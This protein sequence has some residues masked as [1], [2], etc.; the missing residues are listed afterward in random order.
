MGIEKAQLFF[1]EFIGESAQDLVLLAQSG[2]ARKNFVGQT[3]DKKYIITS[4][5][6]IAENESF[7]YFSNLFSDLHLNT[8]EILKI[9]DD[10]KMY[11]QEFLGAQTLSKI[12]ADEGI[13]A[14]T[15]LWSSRPLQNWLNFNV[16]RTTRLTTQ[17]HLSTKNTTAC[18][19]PTTFFILRAL[20]RTYSRFHIINRRC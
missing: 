8:P 20:W 3:T 1:G 15:E 2:S 19:L 14:R 17:K 10:R 6:N 9:S 11:V 18:R 12:V 13:N 16:K 4:N 5:A 7:F